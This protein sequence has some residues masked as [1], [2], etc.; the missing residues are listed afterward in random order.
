MSVGCFGSHPEDRA[1]ARELDLYLDKEAEKE[2]R[3]VQINEYADYLYA[4]K[5]ALLPT[6]RQSPS[7][8][9]SYSLLADAL[10]ELPHNDLS[11][12]A[13]AIQKNDVDTAGRE[14]IRLVTNQLRKEAQS[15]AEDY[16]GH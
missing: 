13:V 10:D 8:I 16:Y 15:D 1:M 3:A 7:G 9:R 2:K 11:I 5:L 14:I 6:M 4:A 12:L